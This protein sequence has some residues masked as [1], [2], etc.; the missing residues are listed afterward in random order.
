MKKILVVEGS[1]SFREVLRDLLTKARFQVAV[2]GDGKEAREL[3]ESSGLEIDLILLDLQLPEV[4]GFDLLRWLREEKSTGRPPILAMTGAYDLW[5]ILHQ[6]RGLEALGVQ[7]K[8]TMRDQIVYRVNA[9]LYPKGAE[10]RAAPRA[11]SEIPVNYRMAGVRSQGTI[12]NIS[13]TGMFLSTKGPIPPH[14]TEVLLQFILPGLPRLFEIKGRVVWAAIP[15]DRPGPAG[16]GIE[17]MDLDERDRSQIGAFVQLEL[18]KF[19][20]SP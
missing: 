14:S 16:M 3:L 18:Q 19:V 5:E 8:R 15:T 11:A 10:Q 6:L 2:A 1:Q 20:S 17:F 9:I 12:S 7:D 4:E 13:R